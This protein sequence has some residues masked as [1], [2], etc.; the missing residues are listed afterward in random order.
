MELRIEIKSTQDG[1]ITI[2]ETTPNGQYCSTLERDYALEIT[3]AWKKA[4][5]EIAKKFGAGDVEI[6]KR[7]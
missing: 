3:R 4:V 5:P 6:K 7:Q 1:D 2:K